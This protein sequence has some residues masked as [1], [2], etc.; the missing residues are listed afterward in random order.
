MRRRAERDSSKGTAMA[1]HSNIEAMPVVKDLADF[2]QKSGN[3]LERVIFNNRLAV[4]VVCA[5]VTA[6]LAYFA[7]RTTLNASYEKML[8]Q[9]HPYVANYLANKSQLRGLHTRARRLRKDAAAGA[10]LRGQLPR[11]QEPAARA[12]QHVAR[13]RREHPGR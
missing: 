13:R 2:D 4:V 1:G 12:G 11:Q 5:I 10:S 7:V 6:I 3:A 8:P 9:G